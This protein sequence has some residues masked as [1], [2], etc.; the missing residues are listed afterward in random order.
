M[1]KRSPLAVFLL[2]FPTLGIYA[3]YWVVKTKGEMNQRGAS[4]PTAW[5]WLLPIVGS[6]FWMWKY[7][8]GVG[9]VTNNQMSA[10]LAFVLMMFTGSIG[11]AVF[12]SRYNQIG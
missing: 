10:G 9:K 1:K 3:W 11:Y 8:E 12:Q 7:S 4:I 6:L 5:I 2:P